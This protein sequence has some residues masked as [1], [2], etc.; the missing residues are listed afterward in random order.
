VALL[1]GHCRWKEVFKFHILR[2]EFERALELIF[3]HPIG[4]FDHKKMFALMS[5]VSNKA[6][7]EKV[8]I[9]NSRLFKFSGD[10]LLFYV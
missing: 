2:S 6:L 5:K 10:K 8:R 1:S 9:L 7:I 3:S 4:G